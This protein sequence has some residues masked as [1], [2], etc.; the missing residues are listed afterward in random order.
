MDSID[1]FDTA[2]FRDVY[3]PTDLFDLIEGK[4]GNNFKKKRIE[5]ESLAM[6]KDKFYNIDDIY[7][8]L[9]EFSVNEEVNMEFEH[10]YAN[11]KIL[12]MYN[13]N[14]SNYIFISDMY[15]DSKTLCRLLSKCGYKNPT[16]YVSC[17]EKCCKGTG[18]LFRKVE[19]R[20][21]KIGTHYGD[22]YLADIVGAH[23]EGIGV[24][25]EPALHKRNLKLPVTH[26]TFVKK[27]AA[28]LQTE[29]TETLETLAKWYAPL[30]YGF[31]EW[32][33]SKKKPGQ[34]I[35]FLARDMY[36]P[37]LIAKKVFNVDNIHYL[38][39]SRRSLSPLF[40]QSGEKPLVDKMKSI[41]TD[42][43]Y[44]CKKSA[45]IKESMNYLNSMGIKDGDMIVDIGYSGSTQRIIEKYLHIQLDGKYMQL[46]AVP[47]Q[48]KSMKLEQ[49]L[50]RPVL[51]YR[52]LAEFVLSSPE[53]CV[54]DYRDGKV[55]F[56][57]DHKGRKEYAEKIGRILLQPSLISKVSKL[58]IS[59]FDIEQLL[60]HI[61]N[62]L[63]DDMLD[64]FN[65]PILTNRKK[66]ERGIG[67][68][69][70]R[71]L[72]GEL[73][74]CY[75]ESYAKPWFKKLLLQDEV[76]SSLGYLLPSD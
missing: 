1:I 76:L 8:Y 72:N 6:K 26:N 32:V 55:V 57:P 25:F 46:D 69:R 56:I 23:K 33:V 17:E 18:E 47:S 53:D 35:F 39:C 31:T 30:I 51:H 20:I 21:G 60:I 73:F 24:S 3:E 68:D 40:I 37:Y 29:K 63:T 34:N 71:I 74:E 19:R 44:K 36:L 22:N 13:E 62:N 65:E 7:K 41:L 38:Y 49:F 52:F 50:N 48:Y 12:E 14:P 28:V 59:V 75:G 67:F 11:P 45:G 5:A 61:Q 58:N 16:V 54:E 9:P 43:E 15:L 64:L 27:Y 10:C 70:D 2:L 66:T 4:V 42:E